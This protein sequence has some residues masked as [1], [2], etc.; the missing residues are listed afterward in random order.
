MSYVSNRWFGRNSMILR[1]L[2]MNFSP[3]GHFTLSILVAPQRGDRWNSYSPNRLLKSMLAIAA[4]RALWKEC[5]TNDPPNQEIPG[6]LWLRRSAQ[7]STDF[8]SS[9]FLHYRSVMWKLDLD[10]KN[11][12]KTKATWI[13]YDRRTNSYCSTKHFMMRFVLS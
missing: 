8:R 6:T 4:T 9:Y 2:T 12:T 13:W 7:P 11:L 10:E 1:R 3:V 5:H